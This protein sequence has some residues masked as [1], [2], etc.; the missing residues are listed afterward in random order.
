MFL[1]Y[2]NFNTIIDMEDEPEPGQKVRKISISLS[3]DVLDWV[4]AEKGDLKVSTFINQTLRYAMESKTGSAC[5]AYGE[6][7]DLKRRVAKLEESMRESRE[8]R[9]LNSGKL[10]RTEHVSVLSA[11]PG[12]IFGELVGIKNVSAKNATA[13]YEELVP[14]LRSREFIDRETVLRELFPETRSSITNDINYWYNA[15]RGVLDHLVEEGFVRRL[16]KNKYRWVGDKK[17]V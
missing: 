8:G 3:N 9:R 14:F 5:N 13:V 15:C 4:L 11:R 2:Y 16:G 17:P 10:G 1:I 6:L 12:D 7:A